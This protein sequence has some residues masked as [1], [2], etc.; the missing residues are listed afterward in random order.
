[1]KK[2]Q[3]G[4][5]RSRLNL[6]RFLPEISPEPYC[7]LDYYTDEA[8]V[9]HITLW[10]GK[11]YDAC[12]E[13]WSMELSKPPTKRLTFHI[14]GVSVTFLLLANKLYLREQEII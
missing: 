1:M 14:P 3:P 4:Y 11:D 5:I 10:H 8:G 9:G 6:K 7:E 2:F 12:E 13:K